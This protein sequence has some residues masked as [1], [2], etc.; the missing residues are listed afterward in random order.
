[1]KHPSATCSYWVEWRRGVKSKVDDHWTNGI[2]IALISTWCS[3]FLISLSFCVVF[4]SAGM[5]AV[6]V[7]VRCQSFPYQPSRMD[8]RS[9][10]CYQ[11]TWRMSSRFLFRNC[12]FTSSDNWQ[13]L[14]SSD[15][16]VLS[17]YTDNESSREKLPKS[18]AVPPTAHTVSDMRLNRV[19]IKCLC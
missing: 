3:V 9:L 1:M 5:F 16:K 19:S 2:N 11:R 7:M 8:S 15:N 13:Q 18:I 17:I 14:T 10:D 6:V 4:R 12:L